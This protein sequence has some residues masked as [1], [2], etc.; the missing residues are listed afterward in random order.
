MLLRVMAMLLVSTAA[1]A[2]AGEIAVTGLRN[3]VDKSYRRM[4]QGV[5][6][7]HELQ[8]RAPGAALRYKLLPRK[9]DTRLDGISLYIVADSFELPVPVAPDHTFTLPRDR[10]ALAEDASVRPDR[11]AGTMTWRAQIRTPG[12]PA[13]T[14]RLGDLRLECR[15]GM[16]AG[17]VSED[18]PTLMGRLMS[19]LQSADFCDEPGAPYLFFSP[20]PLFGVTL[21]AGG[22]RQALSVGQLYAGIAHGRTPREALPYCDCEVLLERTFYLP[23]GAGSWPDDTLVELEYMDTP[24]RAVP[25][26]AQPYIA[27]AGNKDDVRAMLGEGAVVRFESSVEVWTYSFGAATRRLDRT[28]LVLLFEPSGVLAKSR[29]RPAPAPAKAGM[30][31]L[32]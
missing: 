9:S 26:E 3:T 2:A 13:N 1:D 6:L 31:R 16:E 12:L 28:E 4:M 8:A 22:R 23:L 32:E 17:L 14:L 19:V 10:K 7:F 18:P 5:E 15:V 24:G 30:A 25:E 21:S 11:K 20:R 27:G 29:L